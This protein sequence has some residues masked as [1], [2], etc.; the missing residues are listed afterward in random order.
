M[1][2]KPLIAD[3]LKQVVASK[4]M[5][6]ETIRRLVL[7]F[8]RENDADIQRR[9]DLVAL[10]TFF[11]E[12]DLLTCWQCKK[13]RH[14]HHHGFFVDKYKLLDYIGSNDRA[15]TFLAE[16]VETGHRVAVAIEP[17]PHFTYSVIREFGGDAST[18]QSDS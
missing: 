9:N 15:S 10:T 13:L 12:K 18:Q 5:D 1:H 6:E 14:G 17:P 7:E 16:H 3:F 2:E 11:I 8:N 4:L